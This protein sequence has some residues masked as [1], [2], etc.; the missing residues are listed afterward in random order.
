MEWAEIRYQYQWRLI[1][2]VQ[3]RVSIV[4]H[5]HSIRSQIPRIEFH[6]TT[7]SRHRAIDRSP[8]HVNSRNVTTD[9]K[10]GNTPSPTQVLLSQLSIH[11]RTKGF[12]R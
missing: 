3:V 4:W 8:K 5:H 11:K 7:S 9:A 1:K 2:I 12:L 6:T 10:K